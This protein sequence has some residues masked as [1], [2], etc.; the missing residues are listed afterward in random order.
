MKNHDLLYEL[1]TSLSGSEK[2]Y[3]R[4]YAQGQGGEKSYLTLFDAYTKLKEYDP[5][6]LEASLPDPTFRKRL[7]AHKH[8][9]FQMIL[10]AMRLYDADRF[11]RNQIQGMITDAIFLYHRTLYTASTKLFKKARA[12]AEEMEYTPA[13]I[14][15]LDWER[16]LIKRGQDPNGLKAL[17]EAASDTQQVLSALQLQFTQYDLYDQIFTL[18]QQDLQLR[19]PD[20]ALHFEQISASPFLQSEALP[21]GFQARHFYLNNLAN[22]ALLRKDS[23]AARQHFSDLIAHWETQ[24]SAISEDAFRFGL[25]LTNVMSIAHLDHNYEAHTDLLKRLHLI[26]P[27][28]PYEQIQLEQSYYHHLLLYALNTFQHLQAIPALPK[29][30]R[31]IDH[32]AP[33]LNARRISALQYNA[34]TLLFLRGEF[35]QALPWL[36]RVATTS[37]PESAP[38]TM[39]AT[40]L[41]AMCLFELGDLDALHQLIRNDKLSKNKAHQP[42]E[43]LILAALGTV[44][45]LH[46]GKEQQVHWKSLSVKLQQ[47]GNTHP[48]YLAWLQAQAQGK[49][50]I[51]TAKAMAT[52]HSTP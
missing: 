23:A 52:T 20:A 24:P 11:R 46:P 37:S 45:G 35:K 34:A 27:R 42:S 18:L 26:E 21:Q 17:L 51:E 10:R 13:I 41:R 4:L 38:I 33:S 28:S 43:A 7:P 1:I 5:D 25:I 22:L 47:D 12:L 15:I 44:L 16:K 19:S 36:K 48:E 14:E 39:Q 31:F 2:R 29:M 8:Y 49:P 9:L 3:F 6:T 30:A 50:I 32:H 40:I